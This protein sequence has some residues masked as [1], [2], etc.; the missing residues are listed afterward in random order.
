MKKF[1]FVM[2]CIFAVLTIILYFSS[3]N[4]LSEQ[5]AKLL[6]IKTTVNIQ[7]TVFCAASAVI[8][9]MN[10]IGAIILDYLDANKGANSLFQR[11]HLGGI[12]L[13]DGGVKV[14]AGQSW[15]CPKCQTINSR[16][17]VTCCE[18]GTSRDSAPG[19][20]PNSVS[21]LTASNSWVCPNCKNRNPLSKVECRECGTIRQ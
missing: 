15:T 18:C 21:N 16:S 6:G 2:A 14:T 10:I 1:L 17:R 7:G 20:S 5:E 4:H 8:C 3:L 11:I 9:A 13:S 19:T 12:R